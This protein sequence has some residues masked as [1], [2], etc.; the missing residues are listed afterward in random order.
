MLGANLQLSASAMQHSVHVGATGRLGCCMT[1]CLVECTIAAGASYNEEVTSA[2]SACPP[3]WQHRAK[4]RVWHALQAQRTRRNPHK[5]IWEELDRQRIARDVPDL[6]H[7]LQQRAAV[8]SMR[9][10][11]KRHRC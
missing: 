11:R 5:N 7:L 4:F 9:L 1:A 2:F 8:S 3:E 6:E 10:P